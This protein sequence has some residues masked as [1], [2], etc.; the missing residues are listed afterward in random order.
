MDYL[1]QGCRCKTGCTTCRCKCI[2]EST[3]CGPSCRCLN[4]KNIPS[5]I[6]QPDTEQ[7]L[8]EEIQ[9]ELQEHARQQDD[10]TDSEEFDI[11]S[12]ED[13]RLDELNRDVNIIMEEVFGV[14]F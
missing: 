4:C 13:E 11:T 3:Q 1:T 9:E 5:Y 2:K 14:P 10:H 7:E 12:D 8:E 6:T